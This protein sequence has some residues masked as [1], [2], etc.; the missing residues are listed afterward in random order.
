MSMD[1]KEFARL[2]I[3]LRTAQ[4]NYFATKEA[5]Y[6]IESKRLEKEIDRIAAEIVDGKELTLL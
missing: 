6:L 3:K 2:V 1:L 4:K 5:R